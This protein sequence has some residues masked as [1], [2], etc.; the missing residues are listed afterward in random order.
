MKRY[1]ALVSILALAFS[2]CG[3]TRP[4]KVAGMVTLDGKPLG[5]ATIVFT[6]EEGGGRQASALSDDDGAFELTTY[7]TGDGALPGTYKVMVRKDEIH[8]TATTAAMSPE[9]NTKAMKEFAQ[10]HP[11]PVIET[12]KKPPVPASYSSPSSTPLKYTVPVEDKL[13][14]KLKS[15]VGK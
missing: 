14:I 15:S 12:K 9:E 13:E 4:V 1:V 5:G 10:K 11:G 8:V 2:G 7:N 3:K 6:P